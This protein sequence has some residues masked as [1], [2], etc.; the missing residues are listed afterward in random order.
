MYLLGHYYALRVWIKSSI[1]EWLVSR[2]WFS[3]K[4]LVGGGL[5]WVQHDVELF[6][7]PCGRLDILQK[8]ASTINA[9]AVLMVSFCHVSWIQ[10][11]KSQNQTDFCQ[12]VSR[13]HKNACSCSSVQMVLICFFKFYS[14]PLGRILDGSFTV[15][16]N[17]VLTAWNMKCDMLHSRGWRRS[18]L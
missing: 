4:I 9:A 11:L 2:R 1:S 7:P 5:L 17:I 13:W 14:N 10:I 15:L 18:G 3:W 12:L 6:L 8:T 16:G